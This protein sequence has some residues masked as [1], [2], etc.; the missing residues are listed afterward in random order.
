MSDGG[1]REGYPEAASVLRRK[2]A[3]LEASESERKE[4]EEAS[5]GSED[6]QVLHFRNISDV[7]YSI[8]SNLVVEGGRS[9]HREGLEI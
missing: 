2:I 5:R 9:L 8:T 3:E 4:A 7:I 6:N 1:S